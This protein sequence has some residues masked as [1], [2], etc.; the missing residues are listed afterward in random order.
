MIIVLI[1]YY[2]FC[3]HQYY[4]SCLVHLISVSECQA[5]LRQ[6]RCA[7]RPFSTEVCTLA[8]VPGTARS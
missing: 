6:A 4:Y 8:K 5:A 1:F 3:Q 2:D 7:G